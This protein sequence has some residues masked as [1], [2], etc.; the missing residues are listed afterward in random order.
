M[1]YDGN[2]RRRRRWVYGKTQKEV[3]GKLEALKKQLGEGSYVEPSRITVAALLKKFIEAKARATK[4]RTVEIYSDVSRRYLIPHLGAVRLQKL[5]PLQIE[6]ALAQ[7]TSTVSPDAAAKSR[8]ILFRAMRQAVRWGLTSR[9]PVEA[10]ENIRVTRA[11]PKLW[12][13]HQ[14]ALFFAQARPHRLFAAFYVG[15][16]LWATAR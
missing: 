8:A 11:K 1:G 9:N 5:T 10:V 14:A 15:S 3:L 12:T 13:P 4:A 16:G 7:I 6:E 2:G